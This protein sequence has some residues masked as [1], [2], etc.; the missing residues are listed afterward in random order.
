MSMGI[1]VCYNMYLECCEGELDAWWKVEKKDR[2]TFLQ[3][4]L[5]LLEQML[6]Y[7]LRNEL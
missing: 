7:D 2:I 1:I 6:T 4:L 3:F 5:K